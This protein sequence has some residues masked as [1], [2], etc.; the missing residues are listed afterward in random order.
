M[1]TENEL[2]EWEKYTLFAADLVGAAAKVYQV[3]DTFATGSEGTIAA[4]GGELAAGAAGEVIDL[5][6][7]YQRFF[8]QSDKAAEAERAKG[9]IEE[10]VRENGDVLIGAAG[11]DRIMPGPRKQ[12]PTSSGGGLLILV[13]VLVLLSE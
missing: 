13:L 7:S 5:Y 10:A 1:G 11:Y 12:P 3:G 9:A 6:S 4:H 8:G 2:E